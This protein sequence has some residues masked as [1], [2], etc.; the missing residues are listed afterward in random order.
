MRPPCARRSCAGGF[1]STSTDEFYPGVGDTRLLAA[2]DRRLSMAGHYG[3]SASDQVLARWRRAST[4]TSPQ[5]RRARRAR[6]DDV[7]GSSSSGTG[8]DFRDARGELRFADWR[9]SRGDAVYLTVGLRIY[10]G[11]TLQRVAADEGMIASSDPLLA[12]A[13]YFSRSLDRD[14]AIARLRDFA[15][16]HPRFM[17]SADSRSSLL[18]YLTRLASLL[19]LPG[20]HWRYMGTF[21]R[22]AVQSRICGRAR[23]AE[24]VDVIVVG[25]GPRSVDRIRTC[26]PARTCHIDRIGFR[27]T[28]AE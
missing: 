28:T 18:P 25:G 17:F 24:D 11:T 7:L 10:P 27:A 26:T 15:S 13:F 6:R 12:P 19:R 21:Q 1:A 14:A 23:S 8:R 9:L 20:P 16:R 2:W 5:R 3:E 4:Q 22:L